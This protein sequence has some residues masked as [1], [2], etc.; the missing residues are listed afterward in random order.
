MG[1]FST[2][3]TIW[4][5]FLPTTKGTEYSFSTLLSGSAALWHSQAAKEFL[6]GNYSYLSLL[7]SWKGRKPSLSFIVGSQQDTSSFC[8]F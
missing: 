6:R 7:K 4:S 2:A 3:Q 1:T 5:T 8:T